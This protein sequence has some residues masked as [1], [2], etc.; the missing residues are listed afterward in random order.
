MNPSLFTQVKIKNDFGNVYVNF[1]EIKKIIK[2]VFPNELFSR[3]LKLLPEK[4]FY[5]V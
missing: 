4:S 1:S 3:S 2:N 5:D